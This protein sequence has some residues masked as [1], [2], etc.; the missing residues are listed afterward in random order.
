MQKYVQVFSF[1][2]TD[3]SCVAINVTATPGK[4]GAPVGI[5]V[6]TSLKER[7]SEDVNLLC[8]SFE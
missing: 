7:H 4:I 8:L 6:L 2:S 3:S 5:Y 1:H